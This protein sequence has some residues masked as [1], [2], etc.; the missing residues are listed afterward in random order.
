M[1]NHEIKLKI[2]SI[3]NLI[4]EKL[5]NI[6]IGNFPN[7]EESK[8]PEEN[9]LFSSETIIKTN[10]GNSILHE[11]Y[12]K[13]LTNFENFI[14]EFS[15]EPNSKIKNKEGYTLTWEFD[16]NPGESKTITIKKDYR[17]IIFWIIFMVI[18]FGTF[19]NYKKE[20]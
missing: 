4:L 2:Y 16:L 6:E 3:N 13:K 7:L 9:F 17:K 12:I 11:K 8:E 5:Y 19:R 15:P 10:N 1:G 20:I 14:S 18:I